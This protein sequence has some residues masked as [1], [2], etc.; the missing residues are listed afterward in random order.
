VCDASTLDVKHEIKKELWKDRIVGACL[1]PD[2]KTIATVSAEA[3][4]QLWDATS[5]ELRM[6]WP[7]KVSPHLA[8]PLPLEYSNDGSALLLPGEDGTLALL[9]VK[10]GAYCNHKFAPWGGVGLVAVSPTGN[11][12]ALGSLPGPRLL[13]VSP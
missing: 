8:G 6:T 5:G 7:V 11:L 1:S 10:A 13:E 3:R 4:A 9:D 12:V 2:G